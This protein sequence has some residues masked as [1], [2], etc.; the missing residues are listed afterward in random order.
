M[1]VDETLLERSEDLGLPVLRFYGWSEAAA[2]FGYSQHWAEVQALTGLRPLIRR[3]TGGGVVHHDHD[4][5][6]SLVIPPGH[7]WYRLRAP[8]SYSR[9]HAWVCAAL[10]R[11]G[12]EAIL[13]EQARRVG[14]GQCFVGAEEA[15]VLVG[16]GKVAGAAQRRTR[17]G[18]LI[19]GSVQMGTGDFSRGDFETAMK[20]IA[21]AGWGCSW[22]HLS[23]DAGWL[24]RAE[25]LARSKY[26]RDDY[27][28]RR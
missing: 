3:P 14:P 4:W 9:L 18:L 25:E 28:Q 10:R 24:E 20:E 23:V 12:L 13:A 6:Y 22:H 27:N 5:T 11:G 26:G 15:D 7:P 16:E 21:T 17:R 1:A 8:E 19:Q 2:T